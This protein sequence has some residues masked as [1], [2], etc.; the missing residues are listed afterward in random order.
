MVAHEHSDC[1]NSEHSCLTKNTICSLVGQLQD[2]QQ[3]SHTSDKPRNQNKIASWK[4]SDIQRLE[5]LI[6]QLGTDFSAIAQ[7][8]GKS[9]DQV[10][11]KFKVMQK[12]NPNFGFEG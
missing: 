1:A 9:R 12:K 4:K 3:D 10:K 5:S 6:L 11:R 2:K 8:I 7:L